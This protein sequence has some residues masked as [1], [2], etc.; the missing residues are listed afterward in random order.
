[1]CDDHDDEQKI[2]EDTHENQEDTHE[3]QEDTHEKDAFEDEEKKVNLVKCLTMRN[4][5]LH[6]FRKLSS[7]LF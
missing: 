2:K 7:I 1:M 4:Y 6:E 3:N 5:L